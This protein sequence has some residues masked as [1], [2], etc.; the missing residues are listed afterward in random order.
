MNGITNAF[1]AVSNFIGGFAR[2]MFNAKGL[3]SIAALTL[4]VAAASQASGQLGDILSA[5]SAAVLAGFSLGIMRKQTT[6]DS[7]SLPQFNLK[8]LLRFLT[9]GTIALGLKSVLS[10]GMAVAGGALGGLPGALIGF[11]YS[12]LAFAHY[13]SSEETLPKAENRKDQLDRGIKSVSSI[14]DLRSIIG[15]IFAK[16]LNTLTAFAVTAGTAIA[17]GAASGAH[18]VLAAFAAVMAMITNAHVWSKV[19]RAANCGNDCSEHSS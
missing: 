9:D 8:S 11:I 18:P 19:Y 6:S 3:F 15:A 7:A 13:A 12:Q 16:P 17:V 2:S 10:I 14:F 5:V 4:L 1:R